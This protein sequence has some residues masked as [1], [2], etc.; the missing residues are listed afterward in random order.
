MIGCWREIGIAGNGT[1]E[2][3]PEMIHCRNCAEYSRGGRELFDRPASPELL[4]EW[5]AALAAA[6]IS[7]K[8]NLRNDGTLRSGAMISKPSGTNRSSRTARLRPR[9]DDAR[10]WRYRIE[11]TIQV[12]QSEDTGWQKAC[13]PSNELLT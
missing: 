10:P 1:C 9:G 3:L 12:A 5:N 8:L 6:T 4:E 11:R 2:R 7:R 13:D